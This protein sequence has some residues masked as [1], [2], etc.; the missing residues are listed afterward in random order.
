MDIS[1]II[2]NYNTRDLLADCIE[3]IIG[4]TAGVDYEII[5]VDN[6]SHDNSREAITSKFKYIKWVQSHEGTGHIVYHRRDSYIG[7]I[8]IF[9]SFYKTQVNRKH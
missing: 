3:S 1:V 9:L 4:N 8:C 2:V 6:A 7:R 5:I